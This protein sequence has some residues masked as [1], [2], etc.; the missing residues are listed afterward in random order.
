VQL[1]IRRWI[2]FR[3]TW[4][5]NRLPAM[6]LMLQLSWVV[7]LSVLIPLC[8]GLWLDRRFGTAPLFMMIAAAVGIIGGTIGVVRIATRTME[9]VPPGTGPTDE[10]P[11]GKEDRL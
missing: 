11:S 8:A 2:Q 6:G 7:A 10:P 1:Q 3:S 5:L 4:V 9:A